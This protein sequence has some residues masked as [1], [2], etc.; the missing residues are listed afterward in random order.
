MLVGEATIAATDG[1]II[2]VGSGDTILLNDQ[3][4]KG[5]LTQIQGAQDAAFLL[6]GLDD[7][8]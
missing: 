4:S 3:G 6:I 1:D 7:K 5:H 8:N 2:E